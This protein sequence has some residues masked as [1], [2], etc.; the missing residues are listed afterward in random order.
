MKEIFSSNKDILWMTFWCFWMF[1][2]SKVYSS[3]IHKKPSSDVCCFWVT[4]MFV[5]YGT[6]WCYLLVLRKDCTCMRYNGLGKKS[7]RS[8]RGNKDWTEVTKRCPQFFVT[9]KK[10]ERTLNSVLK[11]FSL[12]RTI[13][14]GGIRVVPQKLAVSQQQKILFMGFYVGTC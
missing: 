14:Y 5:V 4:K 12:E 3:L 8:I 11:I 2:H 13:S 6:F 9:N 1:L 7:C 10:C